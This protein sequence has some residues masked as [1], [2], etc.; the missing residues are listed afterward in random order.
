[1]SA[2]APASG[3]EPAKAGAPSES[4]PLALDPLLLRPRAKLKRPF[5]PIMDEYGYYAPKEASMALAGARSLGF[6]PIVASQ[7]QAF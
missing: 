2:S 1:M 7:G 5:V 4:E 6:A 3:A